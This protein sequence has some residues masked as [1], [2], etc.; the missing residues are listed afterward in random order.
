[1]LRVARE[2]VGALVERRQQPV[3][4]VQRPLHPAAQIDRSDHRFQRV[5]EPAGVL[6]P[7]ASLLS[8]AEQQQLAEAELPR[9]QRQRLLAHQGRAQP[10]QIASRRIGK[11]VVHPPRDQVAEDRVAEELE[12]LVGP[13]LLARRRQRA[14]VDVAAVPQRLEGQLGTERS[15][16][17]A[18]SRR[19][20]RDALLI[21]GFGHYSLAASS[22]TV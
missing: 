18:E 14:L 17:E 20:Q 6:P 5:G 3:D 15:L 21:G 10:R 9:D 7:S 1:G 11:S 16:R 22:A 12:A 4:H 2:T 19:E 8:P 13:E